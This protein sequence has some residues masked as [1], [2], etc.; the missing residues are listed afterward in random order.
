[1]SLGNVLN[2][3]KNA[4]PKRVTSL[5]EMVAMLTRGLDEQVGKDGKKAV[6]QAGLYLRRL[7]AG[8]RDL[9]D[10]S[11]KIFKAGTGPVVENFKH[12]DGKLP[13]IIR[14]I[15]KDREMYKGM[16]FKTRLTGGIRE[17]IGYLNK[18]A[19][20]TVELGGYIIPFPGGASKFRKLADN[21]FSKE[22]VNAGKKAVGKWKLKRRNLKTGK[23]ETYQKAHLWG[24]GFGDEA[25]DGIMYAPAEFNQFWQ[26]KGVEAWIREL[27]EQAR[28][29]KG[30]LVVRARATSYSPREIAAEAAKSA[31]KAGQPLNANNGE[32]LLKEVTYELMIE[33]PHQPGVLQPLKTLEFKIPAPWEP[34]KSLGLPFDPN[35]LSSFPTTLF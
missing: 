9:R 1:M 27:G 17:A 24:H 10:V 5:T 23:L 6:N 15:T 16:T 29:L 28:A 18:N 11:V 19:S 22:L 3:R 35:D 12:G 14:R 33:S 2:K 20:L 26:N 30:N 31:K 7:I 34:K 8:L 21:D 25:R 13:K 4:R 32:Y